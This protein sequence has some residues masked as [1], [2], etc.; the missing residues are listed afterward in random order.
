MFDAIN[1]WIYGK[2][3]HIMEL[4]A[5]DPEP[6]IKRCDA[7]KYILMAPIFEMFLPVRYITLL[8]A[9]VVFLLAKLEPAV[10]R[11]PI[12]IAVPIVLVGIASVVLFFLVTLFWNIE[13]IS[14]DYYN[15]E[16][17]WWQRK[18]WSFRE[19]GVF[20]RLL[21]EIIIWS[22]VLV[23]YFI[24]FALAIVR[25]VSQLL[26]TG[27]PNSSLVIGA[28]L[29]IGFTLSLV[30]FVLIC[31]FAHN[32]ETLCPTIGEKRKNYEL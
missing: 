2:Y 14:H 10:A 15:F 18:T 32:S 20:T 11:L 27:I 24:G 5:E 13:G 31:K 9:V 29:L 23:L 3:A 6:Q 19:F 17:L 12:G 7:G 8:F 1:A 22:T 28:S 25:L 26:T 4:W 16:W 30:A 21:L